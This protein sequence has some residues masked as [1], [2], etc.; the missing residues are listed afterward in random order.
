MAGGY[1]KNFG[2]VGRVV[3]GEDGFLAPGLGDSSGH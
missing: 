3:F 2:G 1:K